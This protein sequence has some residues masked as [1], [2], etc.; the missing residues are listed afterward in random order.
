MQTTDVYLQNFTWG[1]WEGRTSLVC[2]KSILTEK[3]M[4]R[5]FREK[6][7]KGKELYLSV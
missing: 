4:S 1:T 5:A 2:R 3:V 6:G 7:K